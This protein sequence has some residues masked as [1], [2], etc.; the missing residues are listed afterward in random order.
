MGP[1]M[2]I[3]RWLAV[4]AGNTG[5]PPLKSIQFLQF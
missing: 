4:Y 1:D 3:T 5:L 2:I